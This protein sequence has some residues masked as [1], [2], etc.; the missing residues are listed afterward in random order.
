MIVDV[1]VY[2]SSYTYYEYTKFIARTSVK[3][4]FFCDKLIKK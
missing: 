4:L 1:H 2:V 3:V